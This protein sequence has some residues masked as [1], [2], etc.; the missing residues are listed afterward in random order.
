[1]ITLGVIIESD[2]TSKKLTDSELDDFLNEMED[3]LRKRNLE[4]YDSFVDR[5]DDF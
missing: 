2:E 3:L 4:I 5:E 1:M